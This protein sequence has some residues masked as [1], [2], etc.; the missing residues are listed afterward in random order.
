MMCKLLAYAAALLCCCPVVLADE[1]QRWEIPL[2]GN[3]FLTEGSGGPRASGDRIDRDGLRRWRSAASVFSVF[4]RIEQPAEIGLAL[5]LRV[6]EGESVIRLTVRGQS[7]EQTVRGDEWQSVPFGRV[8]I[9]QAGHVRVDLQGVRQSGPMFAEATAL[10]VSAAK[11]TP[12]PG[13]VKDNQSNRFYWGRRGPSV[14]LAY[15]LPRGKALTHYYS[16]ITVPEGEDPIGSY[17]MANGFSEGYFGIQVNG[18]SER[19]VLFSVWSPFRTDN[20]ADVPEED[21]V[22]L[23]KKGDGVRTGQ[24]GNEGTG[25]QSY[26]VFPWKAGVTYRFLTAAA[27]DG[28][29]NTDYTAW[30]FAPEAGEWKLIASFRR[31]K[32]DKHLTGFHSFLENFSDVNG[33]RGRR[34][35]HANQWVRDTDGQW[36][37]ITAARFTGDDIA[38][39]RYRTDYAGW[40]EGPGFFLRNG[41]F[42]DDGVPLNAQLRRAP[43]PPGRPEIDLDALP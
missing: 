1:P 29:G 27:P 18:P 15:S 5:R 33:F 13:F 8:K 23:L 11:G 30:F 41:G 37:E 9:D 2:A 7:F 3:A 10:I 24:F 19:R 20:P 21:R 38:R 4:F 34:S 42:F 17:F 36:H 40:S 14:H 31:P 39:R 22:V 35:H 6:P 28:R 32:T 12:E 25:G 43:N 26:L 16:E